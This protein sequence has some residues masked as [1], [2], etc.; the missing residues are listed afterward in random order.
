[1]KKQFVVSYVVL[2]AGCAVLGTRKHEAGGA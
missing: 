1:M 2:Y